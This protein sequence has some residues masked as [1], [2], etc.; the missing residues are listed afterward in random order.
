MEADPPGDRPER[1]ADAVRP[2]ELDFTRDERV[3]VLEDGRYVISTGGA[4]PDNVEELTAESDAHLRDEARATLAEHVAAVDVAHGFSITASFDDRVEQH[5]AFS[6]DLAA[7]FDELV[8]WYAT[9]VA[10]RTDP[11][12]VIGILLLAG[13][14][15]VRFPRRALVDLLCAHGVSP[16]DSVS[17]LITALDGEGVQF[18]PDE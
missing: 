8:T 9:Q 6:E 5:E 1:E 7:V 11:A 14:R 17:D 16:D 2:D 4:L 18:P 12:E 3:A 15:R 10:D 13:E